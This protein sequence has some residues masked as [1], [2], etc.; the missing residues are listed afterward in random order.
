MTDLS[1][2]MPESAPQT[3]AAEPVPTISNQHETLRQQIYASLQ[4]AETQKN[5]L[6]TIDRRYSIL[7]ICLGALA[8]F[9]AGQSAV[10]K[11]PLIG[12]WKSTTTVASLLALSATVATGIH[13]QVASPDVLAETSECV[14]KL[15][16]LKVEIVTPTY[17]L[18]A[19]SA[20]YRQ[21]LA[22]FSQVDC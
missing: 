16:A 21:I 20:E 14:A 12:T 13:K 3:P 11:D 5:K 7:N 17:S 1:N 9:I 18:E 4:K 6:K 22:N 2:S 19:V 10:S 8:T 15:K